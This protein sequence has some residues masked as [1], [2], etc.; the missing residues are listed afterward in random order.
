MSL[1]KI[2]VTDLENEIKG[3]T[4]FQNSRCIITTDFD[5]NQKIDVY[6]ANTKKILFTFDYHEC[7]GDYFKVKK[8]GK[9][10]VFSALTANL[11]IP[12]KYEDI[13]MEEFEN[14][15]GNNTPFFAR[16]LNNKYVL[17]DFYGE[18]LN[19]YDYD[20]VQSF[21]DGLSIVAQIINDKVKYGAVLENG[22]HLFECQYDAIYW[23]GINEI[24]KIKMNGNIRNDGLSN[25][26]CKDSPRTFDMAKKIH[27][28]N[29]SRKSCSQNNGFVK[30]VLEDK[31]T[32]ETFLYSSN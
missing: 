26:F 10:G 20:Y 1:V 28:S 32:G 14:D 7:I 12:L 2:N 31:T 27:S 3:E 4:I 16:Q 30:Y 22:T 9:V 5:N 24:G 18:R 19:Y 29:F 23:N 8:D 17:L 15:F 13:S 11:H 21:K 25:F 6:D